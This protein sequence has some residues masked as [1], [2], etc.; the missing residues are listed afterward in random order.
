MSPF[1]LIGIF[2]VLRDTLGPHF[3]SFLG[4]LGSILVVW[5]SPGNRLKFQWILGPP[6]G[7]PRSREHGQEK[8]N[9]G[10]G[11]HNS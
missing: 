7:H 10:P 2:G 9:A 11:G 3:R 4:T 8:V 1:W 6:L 5:E